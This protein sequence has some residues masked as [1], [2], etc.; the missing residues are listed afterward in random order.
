MPLP[1]SI[2]SSVPELNT[3]HADTL[4]HLLGSLI[5]L[6]ELNGSAVVVP[7]VHHAD[8]KCDSLLPGY[9]A[10]NHHP[11]KRLSVTPTGGGYR[12]E[13]VPHSPGVVTIHRDTNWSPA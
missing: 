5:R 7:V 4:V 12:L 13:V 10:D 1:D 6:V 11:L 9:G 2:F 3:D 8:F